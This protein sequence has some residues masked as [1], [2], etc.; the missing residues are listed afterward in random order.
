MPVQPFNQL[1]RFTIQATVYDPAT[2]LIG[3]TLIGSSVP[4]GSTPVVIN[5]A[6]DAVQSITVTYGVESSRYDPR[7]FV[8]TCTIVVFNPDYVLTIGQAISIRAYESSGIAPIFTGKVSDVFTHIDPLTQ[9]RTTTY[10]IV[11]RVGDIA[12]V[13]RDGS[14]GMQLGIETTPNRLT[15]L[16]SSQTNISLLNMDHPNINSLIAPLNTPYSL[17]NRANWAASTK[18]PAISGTTVLFTRLEN[19]EDIYQGLITGLTPG[20]WYGLAGH[21]AIDDSNLPI[22]DAAIDNPQ[23]NATTWINSPLTGAT[24]A[25]HLNGFIAQSTTATLYVRPR[26]A[27]INTLHQL[28]LWSWGTISIP[29]FLRGMQAANI[30]QSTLASHLDQAV[31]GDPYAGWYVNRAGTLVCDLNARAETTP[32]ASITVGATTPGDLELKDLDRSN[33]AT[34]TVN[35]VFVNANQ[36]SYGD[37]DP[38]A[39][40]F[41][42]GPYVDISNAAT[43]GSQAIT[44]DAQLGSEFSARFLAE[45]LFH[46]PRDT[47]TRVDAFLHQ[48]GAG[49]KIPQFEPFARLTVND[50][51]HDPE[52]ITIAQVTHTITA[53]Y[54]VVSITPLT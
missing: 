38:A 9:D 4:L 36:I 31:A 12:N 2:F 48:W 42:Y 32:I 44:V 49:E 51:I 17:L 45:Q 6:T 15:R 13:A 8:G 43:Y 41:T 22:A 25:Q 1:D 47:I 27:G 52:I 19:E 33:N 40:A 24:G 14:V 7:P 21:I 16:A 28:Q 46:E 30:H 53:K 54:W 50:G 37:G 29:S 5:V 3:S 39:L 20:E 10:T 11:D 26:A 23:P 35:T 34:S 18:L